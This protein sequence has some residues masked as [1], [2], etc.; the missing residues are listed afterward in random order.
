MCDSSVDFRFGYTGREFDQETG[1]YYYRSRYYDATVGRFVSEDSIGFAGGDSNLYRYVGNSST[2]AIDPT[3]NLSAEL[4]LLK[5]NSRPG[6]SP[7]IW[8]FKDESKKYLEAFSIATTW[9]YLITEKDSRQQ[10]TMPGAPV[11]WG[12]LGSKLKNNPGKVFLRP[13]GNS[14]ASQA[15]IEPKLDFQQDKST[16]KWPFD[17]NGNISEII[18]PVKENFDKNSSCPIIVAVPEEEPTINPLSPGLFPTKEVPL[19]PAF[20]QN[21]PVVKEPKP[22]EPNLFIQ[23]LGGAAALGAALLEG[24]SYLIPKNNP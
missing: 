2:N 15:K 5:A 6:N 8:Y 7:G 19:Q 11:P 9:F 14:Q 23:I 12:F 4:T 13:W 18:F 16:G 24:A 10:K 20:S 17:G 21:K 22:E 3:G 1:L